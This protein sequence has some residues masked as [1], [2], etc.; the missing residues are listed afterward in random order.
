MIVKIRDYAPAR[1]VVLQIVKHTV[2]LVEIPLGVVMLHPEL[3]TVSLADRAVLISPAVPDVR[4]E[5]GNVVRLF[6]PYPKQFLY[7]SREIS[8]AQSD[9]RELL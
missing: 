6:L 7:R 4:T 5:I 1:R 2:N 9:D 8:S 3:I